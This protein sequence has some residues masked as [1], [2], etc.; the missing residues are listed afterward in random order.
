M[1]EWLFILVIVAASICVALVSASYSASANAIADQLDKLNEKIDELNE[2]IDAI[3]DTTEDIEG[4][5]SGRKEKY[6]NPIDL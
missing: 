2:K 6:V 3:T 5:I 1:K 4:V